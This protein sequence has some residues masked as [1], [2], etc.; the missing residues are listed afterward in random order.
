MKLLERGSGTTEVNSLN[1]EAKRY[2]RYNE[3]NNER[4]IDFYDPGLSYDYLPHELDIARSLDK[5][6][7][8][9]VALS[10]KEPKTL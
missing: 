7:I 3:F 6:K 9:E 10:F 2:V 8:I 4:K 5:N 1:K